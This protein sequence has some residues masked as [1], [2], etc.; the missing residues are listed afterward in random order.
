MHALLWQSDPHDAWEGDSYYHDFDHPAELLVVWKSLEDAKAFVETEA[1]Q[2]YAKEYALYEKS[3][4][5]YEAEQKVLQI[6][7]DAIA[8]IEDVAPNLLVLRQRRLPTEPERK[9]RYK[10]VEVDVR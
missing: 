10:V 9:V 1:D 5:A 2:R 7:R 4:A 8:G 6:A 3:L